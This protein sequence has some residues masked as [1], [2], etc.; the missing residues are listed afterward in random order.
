M[1]DDRAGDLQDEPDGQ[2]IDKKGRAHL[3]TPTMNQTIASATPLKTTASIT[4]HPHGPR[5]R[6]TWYFA[7]LR[8]ARGL[9]RMAVAEIK[10][11]D[12]HGQDGRVDVA[13]RRSCVSQC[14][15]HEG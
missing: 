8:R 3:R 7:D 10:G 5:Y 4:R 14:G 9:G 2:D 13:G 15:R 12:R 1:P 11:A 6:R